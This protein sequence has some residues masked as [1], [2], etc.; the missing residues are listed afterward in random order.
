MST[1]TEIQALDGAKLRYA[2][3]DLAKE[4]PDA[5]ALPPRT[6]CA[7]TGSRR[8]PP[9]YLSRPAVRKGCSS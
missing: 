5:I 9:T 8:P 1:F 6:P 7:I 3:M 4:I 2:F